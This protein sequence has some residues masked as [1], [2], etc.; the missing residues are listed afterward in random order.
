MTTRAA[1]P[2]PLELRIPWA[3]LLKVA[4]AVLLAWACKRLLPFLELLL[5]AALIAIAL[6]PVLKALEERRVTRGKAVSL[7][8]AGV[9]ALCCSFAFF[10]L[11]P[12]VSQVEEMWKTL[13]ALRRSTAHSLES[14]GLGARVVLPLLDLA[15]G[16]EVDAW[17]ARP[18]VWGPP[19]F[20]AAGGAVVVVVLSLYLLLDGQK[21]VAWLLAYA[22]RAHRRRTGDMVPELF[23]VIQAYTTGQL[24]SS[25]LFA[26][27]AV[28]VLTATGVPGV[29]PLALLAALCDV[30][31]VAGIIAVT[32]VTALSALTVSPATALLVGLLFIT[33]H[34]FEAYVLLPRLYGNRLRLSTL[35]VLLAILGGGILGGI[36]GA[37]LALPLVAAYPVVEKHWLD[38][39]LHPDAV[40][41]HTALRETEDAGRQRKLVKAVLEGRPADAAR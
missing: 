29:L 32:G 28:V 40:A 34:L 1:A 21:V 14:G 16:P 10:V 7:L 39:W 3:T 33:Y 37:I 36:P 4:V 26:V 5:F 24:I 19:A 2:A 8:A 11:P 6:S 41:D 15:H 23:S 31:P 38:E 27:F 22:P 35:T 20:E 17:L 12:L 9:V 25:L 13:P 18:L 30:I